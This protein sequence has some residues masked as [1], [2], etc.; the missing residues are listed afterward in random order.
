LVCFK[1]CFSI[2]SQL[3]D[4]VGLGHELIIFRDPGF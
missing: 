1:W 4:R 2:F 3:K